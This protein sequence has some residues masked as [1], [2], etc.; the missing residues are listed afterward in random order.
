MRRHLS[1]LLILFVGLTTGL[2]AQ[3]LQAKDGRNQDQLLLMRAQTLERM[4][5][6]D[7][8]AEIYGSLVKNNPSNQ[9]YYLRL[10]NL[11]RQTNR[12]DDLL[13]II[14][15]RL[16]L[17][18]NDIELV[19]DKA[20]VLFAKNEKAEAQ[21]LWNQ[22]LDNNAAS[23]MLFTRIANSQLIAG[24]TDDALQ[25]LLLGRQRLS[26]PAAYAADLARV[27]AARMVYDKASEEYIRHLERYPQQANYITQQIIAMLKNNNAYP[28]ITAVFEQA[29]TVTPEPAAIRTILGRVYFFEK[30]Y[31]NISRM[32]AAADI[33]KADLPEMLEMARSLEREH[34][35]EPASELYLS[36]SQ[37]AQNADD[38]GQAL[39][40]LA[41]TYERRLLVE[42]AYP[43]LGGYFAG[44][45]FFR[46][47]VRLTHPSAGSLTQ[48]LALYDSLGS[49]LP[50]SPAAFKA[51]YQVAEIQLTITADFDNA[52]K[53]FERILMQSSSKDLALNAGQRWIDAL[54]A[55]GDTTAAN[56][57]LAKTIQRTKS[58]EDD[59]EIIYSRI[60]I[61]INSDNL[62]A[63]N[64]ELKNL[65]GAARP[66]DPLFNDALEVIA[67]MDDN[68]G[69]ENPALRRYFRGE[70]LISQHKL[71][72]AVNLL[73]QLQQQ[74]VPIADEAAIRQ[75][76]L[77][78]FLEKNTPA[79]TLL[80]DFLAER[81]DSP[82]L[83]Q[84]LIWQ[85]ELMQF[86]KNDPV[87]AVPY[88]EELLVNHP[89]NLYIE[90]VRQRLRGIVDTIKKN[91]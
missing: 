71:T 25:T 6:T 10:S 75:I 36:V 57:A 63:A 46:L 79:E 42:P 35:W 62:T 78:E 13:A 33:V 50:N 58:D 67:M 26:D 16:K 19:L 51:M 85:G 52:A 86:R 4:G 77:L 23:P 18:P 45:R 32:F 43:G 70:A 8:A 28:I 81:L 55:K 40:G 90:P 69:P 68:G 9:L 38:R 80:N 3:G 15:E 34:A 20:S 49:T 83:P 87:A 48:A 7:E 74:D 59:P 14:D 24:A 22:I 64:K 29:M 56:E 5:R 17:A 21:T 27:Y 66:T 88:Y 37:K 11:L 73:D 89:T 30:D 54:L 76:Q 12:L 31:N 82:W 47:D 65:T 41:R 72:E 53:G 2:P 91:Q 61:L 84:A 39:L 60:R 44:N 1:T